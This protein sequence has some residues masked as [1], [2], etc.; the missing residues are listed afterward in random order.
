MNTTSKCDKIQT[1]RR[2][3]KCPSCGKGTILYTLPDTQVKNLPV[4][5]KLCGKEAIVN[6]P[7]V[8]VP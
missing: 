4:K 7:S 3:L 2:P 5:C 1:N 8:P 6:I